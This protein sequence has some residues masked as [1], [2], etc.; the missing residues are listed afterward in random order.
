MKLDPHMEGPATQESYEFLYRKALPTEEARSIPAEWNATSAP[1]PQDK[2][3]HQLVEDQ[4]RRTPQATAAVYEGESLS[5]QALDRRVETLARVL[6]RKG[7]GAAC[8]VPLCLE[9]S[10][11]MVVGILGILKAGG[12]YVP[13]EPDL[14]DDRLAYL[15]RDTGARIVL[16]Q[17]RLVERL[18][19]LAGEQVK[20]IAIDGDWERQE[21][22]EGEEPRSAAG[23]PTDPVYVIY[24]SGTTGRPKGVVLE[25]RALCNRIHWMQQA[26]PLG[27]EDRI[28]QKTPYSFDVS[29]WEFFWPLTTGASLVLARAGGHKDPHYLRELIQRAKITVLHFVPSML[30]IF[31][32][33][34]SGGGCPSLKKVIC[35]GE[36]LPVPLKDLFFEHFPDVELHNLY[37]P[38]EAAIDVTAYRCRKEDRLVPIGKP[39]ANTRIYMV[40]GGLKPVPLGD[41][42]ELCIG[43]DCLARGYLNQPELTA[44]KFVD[45]PLEPGARMYRTG[46]LARWLP[47][48]NI[49]YLGRADSQIKIRGNRVELGEI[50]AV[51]QEQDGVGACAVVTTGGEHENLKLAAYVVPDPR[52]AAGVCHQL[53]LSGEGRLG[54][55]ALQALENGLEVAHLNASETEFLYREIFEQRAYRRHGIRLEDGDT[56]LDV[57][58][59]IGLFSLSLCLD[60]E[61]L[62]IHAFEPIPEIHRVL[63]VNAELFGGGWTAHAYG[64]SDAPGAADF[65]YYPH[66]S[67]V[68]G[69]AA[70][71][72]EEM[73]VVRSVFLREQGGALKDA[74][75]EE[76]DGLIRNRLES[77][78]VRCEL[79]TL[80]D[81]IREHQIEVIH[82]L[83]IDVEKM[84]EWVLRGIQDSDWAKIRQLVI[85]VHDA[86][87]RLERIA[88]LLT[89]K[90]FEVA[91]DRD[92]VLGASRIFQVYAR[93][94]C[95]ARA[96]YEAYE[97]RAACA[98]T[99]RVADPSR[100]TRWQG[101]A[102]FIRRLREGLQAKVPDYMVPAAIVPLEQLPLTANGKI[103][104][105]A[106]SSRELAAPGRKK[107]AP[108]RSEIEERL[109]GIWEELLG[110][111]DIGAEDGFFELGGNSL[112]AVRAAD[113]I[114]KEF[115]C[116]YTVVSFLQHGRIREISDYLVA[117]QESKRGA[118][119]PAEGTRKAVPSPRLSDPEAVEAV[120]NRHLSIRR[121]AVVNRSD[122]HGGET[123]V[124]FVVPNEDFFRARNAAKGSKDR[125]DQWISVWE[126]N[127]QPILGGEPS[128]T[129]RVNS[130]GYVRSDSGV[131]IPEAELREGIELV[132]RQLSRLVV[133]VIGMLMANFIEWLAQLWS[134]LMEQLNGGTM[135]NSTEETDLQLWPQMVL[136]CGI[137]MVN[138]IG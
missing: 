25:H 115:G 122:G 62:R 8:L 9:R 45:N 75:P 44:E 117:Q 63:E 43:G 121:S 39:I 134:T 58:A 136:K 34:E 35:S 90:G 31:L 60:R 82:L 120:L 46:D 47:D 67:M 10:L 127:Y 26:Y 96:A 132:V 20:V 1:F 101:Q 106:L 85:E 86:D 70:N 38:T 24:T 51:L 55:I 64:L 92:E 37:G 111:V 17:S 30:R 112:L 118:E 72:A 52:R 4:V 102:A 114:S 130:I 116:R 99:E 107:R 95:D 27:P 29:G 49:E 36:A 7:V 123:M 129:E 65:T 126:Q 93:K 74:A 53:R 2:G 6:A 33:T 32:E 81:V 80:S 12:A 5:Y 42:G 3:I 133:I 22:E 78:T 57:G 13:L 15:I 113:R 11:E 98:R 69:A 135:V 138:S 104:R 50:E 84:E 21:R 59:N 88:G 41:T 48:G 97:A 103:D 105:K 40:D 91:T 124:A 109:T 61:R 79:R 94:A 137:I 100:Q 56:V 76:I 19:R 16:A 54:A 66:L 83:K 28:L 89:G 125:L 131:P 14:P 18:A 119:A 71:T 110:I 23:S 73:A 128:S 108:H 87:G 68:S 77:R